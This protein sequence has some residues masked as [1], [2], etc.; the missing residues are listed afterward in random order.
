M[1]GRLSEEIQSRLAAQTKADEA[2]S[3]MMILQVRDEWQVFHVVEQVMVMM[4]LCGIGDHIVIDSPPSPQCS[5]FCF[6]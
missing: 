2:K 4:M 3:E 5:M 1:S 6:C